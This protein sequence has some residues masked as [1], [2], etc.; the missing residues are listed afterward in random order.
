M[1]FAAHDGASA[2]LAMRGVSVF[3]GDTPALESVTLAVD[4]GEQVAIVGPNGAG[5]STLLRTIAGVLHPSSGSVLVYGH[6]PPGH[7][8]IAYLPQRSAVDWSFPVTARD[9]VMMGRVARLGLLRR[10]T[11]HDRDVV[12]ESIETVGLTDLADRRIGELSGGQQQRMFIGR[13]LAQEA[14]L[15]LMDEPMTGLD[16]TSQSAILDLLT[17]FRRRGV[18]TLVANH[19]LTMSSER[20]DRIVLLNRRV[21]ADGLSGDVL[22]E[23]NLLAAYGGHVHRIRDALEPLAVSDSCCDHGPEI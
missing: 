20:F 10:P 14:G 15:M 22:T 9:V 11:R 13:A 7:I 12:A 8:C 3:L 19:D 5:K 4:G 18:A 1:R 17:E 2:A 6:R 21:I 23:V 16:S